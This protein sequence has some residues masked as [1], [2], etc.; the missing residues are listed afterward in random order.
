MVPLVVCAALAG[1]AA[2]DAGAT[3]TTGKP[4]SRWSATLCSSVT[5]WSKAIEKNGND[6]STQV[7]SDP[8]LATARSEIVTSLG[9][10]VA[11][12]DQTATKL[13]AL[14][15]PNVRNGA[16][17]AKAFQQAFASSKSKFSAAQA[18]AAALPTDDPDAFNTAGSAV[19]QLISA[20]PDPVTS[21]FTAINSLDSSG[22]LIKAFAGQKSC[23]PYVL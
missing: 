1:L 8:D 20:A 10:A 9:Q 5:S 3:T 19:D 4:A 16:K 6:L 2:P 7:G 15:A 17:I 11:L 12:T 23:K 22:N 21:A 13:A 14:G 18:Q